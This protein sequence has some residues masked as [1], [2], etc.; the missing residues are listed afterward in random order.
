MRTLITTG[1]VLL[2]AILFMANQDSINPNTNYTVIHWCKDKKLSWSDFQGKPDGHQHHALTAY[3]IEFN[4][5]IKGD[6]S[7]FEVTCYFPKNKSW[8]KPGKA[9][10]KL[11]KHEQLHFDIAEIHARK[12][13]KELQQTKITLQNLEIKSDEIYQRN[14]KKLNQMQIAYDRDTDHSNVEAKQKKWEDRIAS[15]LT[16]LEPFKDETFCK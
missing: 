16:E 15:L 13:R 1:S 5:S 7:E 14:W 3:E 9:N 8:V 12:L 6:K 4:I 2:I 11:L 10:Y